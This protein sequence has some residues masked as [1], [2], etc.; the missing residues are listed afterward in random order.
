MASSRVQLLFEEGQAV[1]RPADLRRLAERVAKGEGLRGAVQIAFCA[2]ETVRALNKRHRK[3][4]KV[5][6]VLSF[7]WGEADFA[8]E[9]Y[10]ANP[11]A[12]HQAP[13]FKNNYFN[14]L[15]R[16]VVHGMLHLCGHD[17]MKTG[18]R[19]RMRALEDRYLAPPVPKIRKTAKKPQKIP[20]NRIGIPRKRPRPS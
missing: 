5:T 2:D 13:R 16:L 15:R 14:E 20:K 18:E 1:P 17:H 11:Q 3:L 12:K 4:D 9:I 10:V 6:D 7:E 19:V 8:G